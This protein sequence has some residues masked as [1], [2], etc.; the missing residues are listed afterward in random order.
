MKRPI[1]TGGRALWI[2]LVLWFLIGWPWYIVMQWKY[3]MAFFDEFFI[4]D[5]WMRLIKAE[6]P[7]NNRNG[8]FLWYYVVVLAGGS[9]PW[10]PPLAVAVRRA[11]RGLRSS[12]QQAFLW[13]WIVTSFVYLTIAQSK[14]PSY[15][16]YVF[17]PLA[18]VVG[19]TLEDWMERGF[20]DRLERGL[21]AGFAL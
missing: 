15:I 5:N 13:S 20:R 17:V 1:R 21:A 11:C 3:G 2:G 19:I 14:L 8:G 6:H 16:F 7:A 12:P 9:L 10:I 18:M 4:N